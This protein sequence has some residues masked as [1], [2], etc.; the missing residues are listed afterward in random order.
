MIEFQYILDYIL[1]FWGI[2][3]D[4]IEDEETRNIIKVG[5]RVERI[6]LY[7][8]L[9]ADKVSMTREVHR[10]NGRIDRCGLNYKK[11]VPAKLN[12]LVEQETLDHAQ[13]V[14]VVESILEV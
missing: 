8:R 6:D 11:E 12:E 5:K 7:G 14:R 1:A 3:D 13:I 9:K 10:L 4:I 2:V